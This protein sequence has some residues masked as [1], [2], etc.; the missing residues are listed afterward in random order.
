MAFDALDR[1]G[2][3]P[4]R[5]LEDLPKFVEM[6]P[7]LEDIVLDGRSVL[8]VYN[9]TDPIVEEDLED[10]LLA[11]ERLVL[12]HR[13]DLMNV[14]AQLY[15]AWRQIRV[16][17]NSLKGVLNLALTNQ[18]VTQPQNTNPLGFLDQA[19][20]FS[21]VLNA[22][23]PLV[24][25]NERN[26]FRTAIL[27][28]QQARRTLQNTEDS[29]KQLIRQDIRGILVAYQ[30]YRIARVNLVLYARI[31]DQAFEQIVAPPQAGAAGN[32]ALA[33]TQTQNL[34]SAQNSLIGTETQLIT[35]WYQYQQARLSL[36]RDI[37]I[38]PYDE[39][40]AFRAL[41][42]TEEYTRDVSISDAG[43]G[44]DSRRGGPARLTAERPRAA[45]DSG[46][47]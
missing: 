7:E 18:F 47:R 24:R 29:L 33:A 43:D 28:Y 21:L 22:E 14:R 10:L 8:E 13:L 38:L 12:E 35:T 34:V 45:A 20:Q 11:A 2:L 37:G 40:E 16:T 32:V 3:D 44:G 30:N 25:I 41:F 23:L 27:R 15:D 19:K 9:G 31:K 4:K 42:S 46:R 1:W 5:K 6:L 36:Y 17:A 26:N 39:W